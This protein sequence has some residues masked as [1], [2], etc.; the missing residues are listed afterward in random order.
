MVSVLLLCTPFAAF[1]F[2][3]YLY[4][5]D[6]LALMAR[7]NSIVQDIAWCLSPAGQWEGIRSCDLM[8]SQSRAEPRGWDCCYWRVRDGDGVAYF[9]SSES[10][11]DSC[12]RSS[13]P[14]FSVEVEVYDRGGCMIQDVTKGLRAFCWQGNT[15]GGRAFWE[16]YL[17]GNYG[18]CGVEKIVIRAMDTKTF[19]IVDLDPSVEIHL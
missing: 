17:A 11:V 15:I 7:A 10:T 12:Q 3:T 19:E 1:V 9:A 5:R 18:S 13:L 14:Y 16:W 2:Y 4:P 6:G 8:F